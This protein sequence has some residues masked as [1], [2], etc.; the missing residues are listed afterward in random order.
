MIEYRDFVPRMMTP[1]GYLGQPEFET[2]QQAL[3]GANKCIG[4]DAIEVVSIETVVLPN[5]HHPLED[6][7][8]DGSIRQ[9]DDWVT[10]WNQFIRVWY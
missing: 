3:E 7:S 2:L 5:V 4:E 6:G 1:A 8:E 9:D 10:M